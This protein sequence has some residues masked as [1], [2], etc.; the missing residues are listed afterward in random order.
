[1]RHDFNNKETLSD[2]IQ[3]KE[4]IKARPKSVLE[5]FE[6][7][8]EAAEDSKLSE[9]FF[10]KISIY[11][12]YASRK[13]KLSPIQT[14]LLALF[15]DRSEDNSIRISEIASYTGC[16]TTKILRLSSEIDTLEEKHYLRASRSPLQYTI[17][18]RPLR[19]SKNIKK[20]SGIYS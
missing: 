12:R 3:Q 13:L 7:I 20:G 2:E 17:L 1:M 10:E 19:C 6:Y 14:V 8:V 4:T 18:S 15:V 16:R 11:V 5:A 9:E